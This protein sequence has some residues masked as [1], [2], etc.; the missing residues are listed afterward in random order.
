MSIYIYVHAIYAHIHLVQDIAKHL[1]NYARH[2]D[3]F[4]HDDHFLFVPAASS[5]ES[6]ESKGQ[7]SPWHSL[8]QLGAS[9]TYRDWWIWITN[10]RGLIVI[11]SDENSD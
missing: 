8:A 7:A 4:G 10:L 9:K 3:D 2:Q 6:N 5:S 11:D 1:Q